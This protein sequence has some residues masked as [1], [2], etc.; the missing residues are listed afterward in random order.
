MA[1]KNF[2]NERYVFAL[3]KDLA[4]FCITSREDVV[5]AVHSTIYH[6]DIFHLLPNSIIVMRVDELHSDA[7]A[8]S[9]ESGFFASKR[10]E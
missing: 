10:S 2:V 3:A 1:S 7:D 8:W 4:E 9:R 6:L 5:N